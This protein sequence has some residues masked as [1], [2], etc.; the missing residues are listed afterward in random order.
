MDMLWSDRPDEPP[1]EFRRAQRTL[2]R[3]GLVMAVLFPAVMLVT[4]WHP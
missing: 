4:A 1:E 2:R 3:A